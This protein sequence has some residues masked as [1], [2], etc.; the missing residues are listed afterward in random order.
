MISLQDGLCG[1]TILLT[2]KPLK[3]LVRMSQLYGSIANT[4]LSGVMLVLNPAGGT[5]FLGSVILE[6]ILTFVPDVK[7]VY[8]IVR[9]K[10]GRSGTSVISSLPPLT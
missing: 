8:V 2:G 9:D 5:G 1:R 10:R 4:L 3:P 7:R 6:Q